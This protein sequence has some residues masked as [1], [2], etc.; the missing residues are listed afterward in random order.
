MLAFP[1]PHAIRMPVETPPM[2]RPVF[3]LAAIMLLSFAPPLAAQEE[4]SD[5]EGV[6]IDASVYPPF[7]VFDNLYYI[8][9]GWVA[10]W[11]V[12]TDDGLI[13]IDT[14]YDEHIEPML[15]KI[16]I[17][18]FDPADIRYVFVT[19]A[20]FDHCGGVAR[21]K[22]V[23]GATIG[24]TAED[25]KMFANDAGGASGLPGFPAIP[26]DLVIEDGQSI[27]LG[28]TTFNFY[29]TPGHT[30]GVLSMSF[31]VHDGEQTYKAFMYGGPGLNFSGVERTRMYLDSIDRILAMDDIEV[32]IPNHGPMGDVFGRRDRLQERGPDEPHPFVAP[33]DYR[34]WLLEQ[35]EKALLK[36][37]RERAKAA[38]TAE[39]A[40]GRD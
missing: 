27:T 35:R 3:F 18:G 7:Q 24:M 15:E 4:E 36:L 10:A 33:E 1:N 30:P 9:I 34:E 39:P 13:L 37:E 12:V 32:N 8:G 40:G 38:R 21:I 17:L 28:D 19:H 26:T 2:L 16:R 11:L 6:Q 25:W 29:K 20:H 23:T 14:L 22:E 31:P 5:D